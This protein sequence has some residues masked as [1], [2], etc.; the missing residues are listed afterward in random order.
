M[1]VLLGQG[2]GQFDLQRSLR[3]QVPQKDDGG[4]A[5]VLNSFKDVGKLAVWIAAK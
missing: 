2:R 3:L 4:G 5:M 1:L